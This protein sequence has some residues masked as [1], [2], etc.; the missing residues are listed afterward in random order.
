[1]VKGKDLTKSLAKGLYGKPV[2]DN[3]LNNLAFNVE[4]VFQLARFW[5]KSP[6]TFH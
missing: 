5:E 4:T 1:M 6:F 3:I 2:V